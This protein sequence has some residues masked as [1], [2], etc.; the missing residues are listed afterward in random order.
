MTVALATLVDQSGWMRVRILG[1]AT[2]AGLVGQIANPEGVEVQIFDGFFHVITASV[3]AST[4]DIGI[5]ATGADNSNLVSA[6]PVNV[7]ADTV[8]GVIT[9]VATEIAATTPGGILWP[10]ASFLTVTSAA[11]AST[12]LVM[13]LYLRYIRLQTA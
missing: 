12:G 5:G 1:N 6:V 7:G 4:Y 2:A 10:A 13:D 3:A 9:K 8:W 11:A